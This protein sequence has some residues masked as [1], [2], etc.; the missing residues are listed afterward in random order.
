M[1]AGDTGLACAGCKVATRAPA[2][3]I[4]RSLRI[5]QDSTYGDLVLPEVRHE[6]LLLMRQAEQEGHVDLT[7]SMGGERFDSRVDILPRRNRVVARKDGLL[8]GETTRALVVDEQDHGLVLYFPRKDVRLEALQRTESITYCPFKGRASYWSLASGGDD[9]AWTY[10]EPY[11]EVTRLAGLI[12]FY[13]D[14]V[15][16]SIGVATPAGS[17]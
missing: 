10:D 3:A 14:R 1:K 9:V 5:A 12:A 16:V 15:D 4:R 6:N 8:L 2:A 7:R 13:Q 17:R 11:P